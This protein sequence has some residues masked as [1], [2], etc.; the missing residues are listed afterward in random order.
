MKLKFSRQTSSNNK[1]HENPSYGSRVVPYGQTGGRM[2][3]RTK[4][5]DEP[6]SQFCEIACP[7][8]PY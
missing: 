4:R 6:D 2:E 5:C 7:G 8:I 1:F 3:G